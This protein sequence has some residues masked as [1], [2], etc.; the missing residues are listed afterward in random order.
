[1]KKLKPLGDFPESFS[2]LVVSN[3]INTKELQAL[4]YKT[5]I[6]LPN[7]YLTIKANKSYIVTKA[8]VNTLLK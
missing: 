3:L 6:T 2:M 5:Y 1:M 7:Q 4:S 8:L